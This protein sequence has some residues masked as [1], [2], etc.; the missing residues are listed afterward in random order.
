M[1]ATPRGRMLPLARA[2]GVARATGQSPCEDRLLRA[3]GASRRST[4][5][6]AG[7][8]GRPRLNRTRPI[9]RPSPVDA[10]RARDFAICNLNRDGCQGHIAYLVT[11]APSS[12]PEGD[13]GSRRNVRSTCL[14]PPNGDSQRRDTYGEDG[15]RWGYA[16]KEAA[17]RT[18][19]APRSA[20]RVKA[21]ALLRLVRE[22]VR[23]VSWLMPPTES[24][25]AIWDGEPKRYLARSR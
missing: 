15:S 23:K 12:S 2:S 7:A 5:A 19:C 1:G 13:R 18:P 4:A 10:A 11:Q 8:A 9:G 24:P 16:R 25:V 3:R 17:W 20:A 14:C 21:A 22:A 6:L